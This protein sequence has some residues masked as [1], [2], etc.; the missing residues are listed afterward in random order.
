MLREGTCPLDRY[1]T[2]RVVENKQFDRQQETT[3]N[4][5]ILDNMIITFDNKNVDLYQLFGVLSRSFDNDLFRF[6]AFVKHILTSA[7]NV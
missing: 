2:C 3:I 4:T 5:L 1:D 6:F 7:T